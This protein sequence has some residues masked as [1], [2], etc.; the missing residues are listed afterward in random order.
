ML[1][2]LSFSH[3]DTSSESSGYG[4]LHNK[5]GS[6]SSTPSVMLAGHYNNEKGSKSESS[7]DK[8]RS[9]SVSSASLLIC[10]A[11]LFYRSTLLNT[12]SHPAKKTYPSFVVLNL[13]I[14]PS[15]H[16]TLLFL[17]V[18]VAVLLYR[19]HVVDLWKGKFHVRN[20]GNKNKKSFCF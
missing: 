19:F 6:T 4:S 15:I 16:T 12:M 13:I 17:L 20:D 8:S 1:I 2:R 9:R 3:A 11:V 10:V 14:V 5:F 7:E 18:C